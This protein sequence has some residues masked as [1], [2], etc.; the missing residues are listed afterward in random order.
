MCVLKTM[1]SQFNPHNPTDI[2]DIATII[3]EYDS[4]IK[5]M[6]LSTFKNFINHKLVLIN[7]EISLIRI[8]KKLI[9]LASLRKN[10]LFLE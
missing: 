4:K 9:I 5:E 2:S 6:F 3:A 7:C 8:A 1:K 10:S